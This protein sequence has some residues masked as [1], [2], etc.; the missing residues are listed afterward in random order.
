MSAHAHAERVPPRTHA[1]DRTRSKLLAA[2]AEAFAEGGYYGTGRLFEELSRWGLR[3]VEFD[4]TGPPPDGVDLIWLEVPSDQPE[5]AKPLALGAAV[6]WFC[7]F[8]MAVS[9]TGAF[10]SCE[11]TVSCEPGTFESTTMECLS[12]G[13]LKLAVA[14]TPS[15]STA[16]AWNSR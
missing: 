6:I 12:I 15:W 13:K 7:E 11:L 5:K 16:V 9:T 10:T 1:H 3:F 8:V 14:L 4:Q 2:A